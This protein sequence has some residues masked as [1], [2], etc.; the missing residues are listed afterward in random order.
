MNKTR[1]DLFQVKVE[2]LG[3]VTIPMLQRQSAHSGLMALVAQHS[4]EMAHRLGGRNPEKYRPTLEPFLEFFL[5]KSMRYAVQQRI[6]NG[7]GAK[8]NIEYTKR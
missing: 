4:E 6:N 8:L 7:L 3:K 2:A 5:T 1:I